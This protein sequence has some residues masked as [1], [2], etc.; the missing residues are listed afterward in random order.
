MNTGRKREKNGKSGKQYNERYTREACRYGTGTYICMCT[1]SF[2]TNCS[3]CTG[4]SLC[5]FSKT[6]LRYEEGAC[7]DLRAAIPVIDLEWNLVRFRKRRFLQLINSRKQCHC[8]GTPISTALS[9]DISSA[10]LWKVSSAIFII[11]RFKSNNLLHFLR[12][13]YGYRQRENIIGNKISRFIFT[14][15]NRLL[16]YKLPLLIFLRSKTRLIGENAQH[17][18]RKFR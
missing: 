16:N 8:H 12:I 9:G 14:R 1:R 11:H 10:S 5:I 17:P 18:L 4:N 15:E 6:R 3:V 7:E 13:K 2:P